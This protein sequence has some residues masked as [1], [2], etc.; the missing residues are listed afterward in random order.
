[1]QSEAAL[2]KKQPTHLYKKCFFL[3]VRNLLKFE[4]VFAV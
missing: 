1:M 2:K 4:V 3:E